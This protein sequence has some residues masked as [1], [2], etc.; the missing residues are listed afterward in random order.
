M[1]FTPNYLKKY[2]DL[3]KSEKP[4]QLQTLGEEQNLSNKQKP[5]LKRGA[6]F[7]GGEKGVFYN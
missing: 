5:N 3:I 1:T 4:S 6:T 2:F 7:I